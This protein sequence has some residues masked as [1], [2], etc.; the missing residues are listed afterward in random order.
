MGN[1][2]IRRKFRPSVKRFNKRAV[3]SFPPDLPTGQRGTKM[4]V[5]EAERR[6]I[7]RRRSQSKGINRLTTRTNRRF[8]AVA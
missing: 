1:G 3:A 2:I 6:I 4:R 5:S 8:R 7:Q